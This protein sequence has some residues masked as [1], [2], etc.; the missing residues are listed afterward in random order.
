VVKEIVSQQISVI[1]D[2]IPYSLCLIGILIFCWAYILLHHGAAVY[3]HTL[4]YNHK[5]TQQQN[6]S[7]VLLSSHLF[8]SFLI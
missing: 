4:G 8:I 7:H 1:G 6:E 3:V 2:I 5:Q